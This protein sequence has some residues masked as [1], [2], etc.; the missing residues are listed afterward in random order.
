MHTNGKTK[1][2]IS[3][4]G[5]I[6]TIMI[7]V[8]TFMGNTIYAN[9]IRA[10]KARETIRK[11]FQDCLNGLRLEIKQDIKET[12]KEILEAIRNK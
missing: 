10:V 3:L 1:W 7:A 11:D 8:M 6:L 12:K 5:V 9:D 4:V 2:L